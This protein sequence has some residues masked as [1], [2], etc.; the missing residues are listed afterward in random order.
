MLRTQFDGRTWMHR[1]FLAS[2]SPL[3][4]TRIL[5]I[6]QLQGSIHAQVDKQRCLLDN[7]PANSTRTRLKYKNDP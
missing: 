2:V 4:G 5:E 6:R 7:F 1:L 3:L